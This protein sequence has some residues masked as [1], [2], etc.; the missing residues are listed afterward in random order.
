MNERGRVH[1]QYEFVTGSKHP[2]T[3]ADSSW[4]EKSNTWAGEQ[5]TNATPQLPI[6]IADAK[7]I[8]A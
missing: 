4:R 5:K 7:T 2:T 8:P 1:E 6:G 3:D